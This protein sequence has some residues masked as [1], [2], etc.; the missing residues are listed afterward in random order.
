MDT[1]GLAH[2]TNKAPTIKEVAARAGVSI[3][4]VSRVL[5]NE[6]AV[7]PH[8]KEKVEAAVADLGYRPNFAA[9]ALR[10]N[11]IDVVGFIVPDI[12]NPF[13]AQLAKC[14]E[15]EVYK[16]EHTVMLASSYNDPVIELKH[17]KAFLDRSVRGIVIVAASD[18]ADFALKID[19]PVVS[20]DRRFA[21]F[22][23]VSTNHINGSALVAEHLL[24][25]GH[26]RIAYIAGPQNTE[27]GR[28]RQEGFVQRLHQLNAGENPVQLS[29]FPGQFDYGSGEEIAQEILNVSA[30]QR[31][32]A[33]AAASDQ[34]AIG[35]L[36]AARDLKLDVPSQLSVSGFD[37]IMLA[38]LVVPRLTTIRQPTSLLAQRAIDAIF[39]HSN[40][41]INGTIDGELISRG[42]TGAVPKTP[43]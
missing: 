30:A 33:I 10:T 24:N 31:P 8:L 17:I 25:L 11:Q 36:R 15:A 4:T 22:P 32:T 38:E 21:K 19:V 29:V 26:R 2:D 13:F 27:V 23:L 3:G 37:D 6:P 20:L 34:Q 7:K 41:D 14:I 42:S 1:P 16:R 18:N 5:A 35:A 28:A 43:I 40:T 12:T 39:S 9:R